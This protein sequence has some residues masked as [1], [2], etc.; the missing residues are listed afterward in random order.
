MLIKRKSRTDAKQKYQ[1]EEE[2]KPMDQFKEILAPVVVGLPILN[3]V[4]SDGV[5]TA[6]RL[7][8]AVLLGMTWG[9]W[10]KIGMGIALLMLIMERGLSVADKIRKRFNGS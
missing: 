3:E 2:D 4:T 9:A 1:E 7:E 10:F 6:L 8:E 5:I